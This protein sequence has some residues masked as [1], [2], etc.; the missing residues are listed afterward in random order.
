[1]WI[2]GT[3]RDSKAV[4]LVTCERCQMKV[5]ERLATFGIGVR[6]G[7]AA[8]CAACKTP[9]GPDGEAKRAEVV[10]MRKKRLAAPPGVRADR[11]EEGET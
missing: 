8:W 10:A 11:Q 3:I 7:H 6:G 9:D 5:P 1:M 4:E 2:A